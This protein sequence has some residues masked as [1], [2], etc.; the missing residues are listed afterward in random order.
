MSQWID[1]I[2]I[3]HL[4]LI[5]RLHCQIHVDNEIPLSQQRDNTLT[6]FKIFLIE[7]MWILV[8]GDSNRA[9]TGNFIPIIV[10]II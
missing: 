10:L 9:K 5:M 2:E 7:I 8:L 3:K 1:N 6:F 4:V